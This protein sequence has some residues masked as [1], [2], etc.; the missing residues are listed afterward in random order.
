MVQND[1]LSVPLTDIG[2][3]KLAQYTVLNS[4]KRPGALIREG[5]LF[6]QTNKKGGV[7]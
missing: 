3:K 6:F 2:V 7:N 4:S 5:R 1:E